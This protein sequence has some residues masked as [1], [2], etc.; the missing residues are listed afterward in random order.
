M[1]EVAGIYEDRAEVNG[2]I[3]GLTAINDPRAMTDVFSLK[4]AAGTIATI[5][6][7]QIVVD[8]PTATKLGLHVGEPVTVQMTNGGP[9]TFTLSGIYA[10]STLFNGWVINTGRRVELPRRPAVPRP[11]SSSPPAPRSLR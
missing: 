6:S 9:R 1:H 8:Q 10:K 4:A 11:S 2:K 5:D 7:G 3:T